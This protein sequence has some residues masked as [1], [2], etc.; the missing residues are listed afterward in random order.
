MEE[1]Q[2]NETWKYMSHLEQ[3]REK[4]QEQIYS[5]SQQIHSAKIA[6][7]ALSRGNT[8]TTTNNSGRR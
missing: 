1:L 8:G 5:L 6:N 3:E 2:S 7:D 4:M